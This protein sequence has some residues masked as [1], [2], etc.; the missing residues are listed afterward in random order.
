MPRNKL[1]LIDANAFC[2]RAYFALGDLKTSYGQPTAA[3]FGFVNF[4]NKIIKQESPKYIGACFDVSRDTF[5]KRIFSEYKIQRPETPEGLTVQFPLIKEILTA[6]GIAV[7]EKEG[8]EAD[9]IIAT[10]S[11]KAKTEG[12]DAVIISSDKD[13]LQLVDEHTTVFSPYRDK[14][15]FY[16]Q[17]KIKERFGVSPGQIADFI[18]LCGDTADNIPGVKG[19]GPKSAQKLLAEFHSVEGIVKNID[20]ITPEKLQYLVKENIPL[21]NL[22]HKLAVLK[23]D[24]DLGFDFEDLK[25]KERDQLLLYKMF[26]KLEFKSFLKDF[27]LGPGEQ[28]IDSA[29]AGESNSISDFSGVGEIILFFCGGLT[30]FSPEK[31]LGITLQ[32]KDFGPELKNLLSDEK[33]NKTAH[34]L[35]EL[36]LK[37]AK[38]NFKIAGACFDT[39]IAAYIL[40]SS[41]A[42]YNLSSVIWDYL[43]VAANTQNLAPFKICE[44]IA[45]LKEKLRQELKDKDLMPL[46]VE[47]EM[48][49][50]NVL[51]EMELTGVKIDL[52]LLKGLSVH[53]ENEL[54]ALIEKIF[55]LAGASFN[56]NS[57][58]QLRQVLFEHLKLRVVKRTKSGPSTDEEVL[59]SLA[60]EHPL[61]NI[62]L[63][64]RK[65]MKI[66]ST[67]VDAFPLLLD[68]KTNRL[69]TSFNQ[70]GTQTGR[71]SSSRPNLQNL[72]IKTEAGR[73]IR[74][75]II[76]SSQDNCLVSSDY[77]QIE[78]RVLAHISKDQSLIS[79]FKND[80]DIHKFTA[81]LI[82]GLDE[83]NITEEMRE[84]AKRINFGIV[85]GLSAFGLARDLEIPQEE[86]QGFIDAYFLRYPQVKEYIQEQ[87]K[88]AKACG[89]VATILGR[90]RY[91]PEI[92]NKSKAVRQFAERQAV[93]APIQGSASDLIKLAMIKIHNQIKEKRLETKMILQIH[94]E[95]LFDLPENEVKDF[96]V[97]LRSAMEEIMPLDVPVKVEIKRGRN[98]LEMEPV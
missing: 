1:F 42:E 41:R 88:K 2:Y 90:R 77:S 52:K 65:I 84:M 93:N 35:K 22:S 94:D 27:T 47:L 67:Y 23:T 87:I 98:W 33:I 85:Y 57:P 14:G 20:K 34:G 69:H 66:K 46:F 62:L 96:A 44:F 43:N 6:Y 50:V 5:R 81:S 56:I 78:L 53:L 31:K 55:Q 29:E 64:Y 83:A 36:W 24:V 86:A 17:N 63:E 32:E 59:S 15:T 3:I 68:E 72:P 21:I 54:S 76:A 80:K 82:Y 95:L 18:A 10:L 12:F 79:A 70:T 91:I 89:F 74:K 19:L 48:P 30:V 37:L 60:K 26:Q 75:A 8:F 51:A 7:I 92:N 45:G 97:L 4:L 39:M 25:L 58:K 40:N 16:N 13:M 38:H 9:D 73:Q 11:G 71:L 49:L 28:N 61:P